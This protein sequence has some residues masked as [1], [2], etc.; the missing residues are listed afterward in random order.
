MCRTHRFLFS[1]VGIVGLLIPLAVRPTPAGA[2]IT[3]TSATSWG[4]ATAGPSRTIEQWDAL[5]WAVEQVGN[6]VFVGGRFLDVTNG[7]TT[8]R[9]PHFAAFDADTGQWQSWFTPQVQSPVLALQA[10]PDGGL[11]VGGEIDSWNGQTIGALQKIDPRTGA[12]WPGWTT[13][14]YGG[15]SA[16]Q[17]LHLGDDGWLYVVG[18]F[19]T[20][21]RAGL[22]EAATGAVR[23]DPTTGAIDAGWKPVISASGS[24]WGVTTSE[25]SDL[26]YLSGSFLSVNGL[27]GTG[28]FVGLDATASV[29]VGRSVVPFNGCTTVSNT[30]CVTMFDVEATAAG[31]LFV[32]GVEHALYVLDELNGFS[33]VKQH[34]TACNPNLNAVCQ[35]SNWYGG[36]FQELEEA[37][38]RVY[39]V[40]HCW[41]DYYSDSTLIRHT[42]PHGVH[43]TVSSI[44]AIDTATGERIP[45]FRPYLTGDAGGWALHVNPADGCLWAA[46]GFD[47]VGPVGARRSA[48][49]LV[50]L[51]DEA[52]PGPA[53]VPDTPPPT[54]ASCTTS[55]G[56]ATATVSWPT[57]NGLDSVIVE[58][59][60]NNGTWNWRGRVTT[61]TFSEPVTANALTTYRVKYRFTAGQI[62]DP[63]V[64]SPPIDLRVI[65]EP[66]A[67]C[68]ATLTANTVTIGW[69][70]G[71]GAASHVIHRSADGGTSTW[72]GRI[73]LPASTYSETVATGPLYQYVVRTRSASGTLSAPTPCSPPVQVVPTVV[74][75]VASCTA[76]LAGTNA[77]IDWPAAA[78]ATTYI[79]Y[80]TPDGGAASWRGKVDAPGLSYSD[81]L[82][83]GITFTYSVVA[84]GADGTAA[85]ATNCV[86]SVRL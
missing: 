71:A 75:P 73:D 33:L 1:I 55:L 70:P 63:V 53:A 18:N 57:Q 39:A 37:G 24:V 41:Y 62:S 59:Q 38:D 69:T 20:A 48:R 76:T 34:Y 3:S 42:Q 13:R 29:V 79:V 51:C 49:D 72:R 15:N 74:A 68:T 23:I 6:T 4:L 85:A 19:T 65:L 50:R 44:S 61:P 10:S 14:V 5:G 84:K 9:Q 12:T 54:P 78:N 43:S 8:A 81:P 26:V 25:V 36:E 86:P 7:S 40:C 66:P 82:R 31:T 22:P 45:S 21:S 46:G 67:S 83:A 28:G 27:A 17:D 52:G 47:S 32:G 77:V 58:R 11:F 80:R 64:C 2:E 56:G 60:V 30:Y 35:P 16:V